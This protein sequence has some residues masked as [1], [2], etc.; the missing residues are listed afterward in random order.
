MKIFLRIIILI[1]VI[2]PFASKGSIKLDV[3]LIHKKGIDKQLV[4]VSELHSE[5][6][7]TSGENINLQMKN[8]LRVSLKPYFFSFDTDFGP[9][10]KI[11]VDGFISRFGTRLNKV[12]SDEKMILTIG[13]KKKFIVNES[14]E[15]LVEIS[16][17]ATI[18]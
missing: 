14:E 16:L 8:G 1:I 15:Q 5:Q 17:L 12:L 13:E 7:V 10:N 18:R 9:S 3:V 6:L 11:Q 4:L 2:F